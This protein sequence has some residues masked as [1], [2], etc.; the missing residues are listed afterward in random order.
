MKVYGSVDETPG[1]ESKM[2]IA[3]R[4]VIL[5]R[6]D[7]D[8]NRPEGRFG[9]V[10]M[11]YDLEE[12]NLIALKCLDDSIDGSEGELPPGWK[13]TLFEREMDLHPVLD[14][15]AIARAR[16]PV[17]T[18]YRA[19][20]PVEFLRFSFDDY[21]VSCPSTEDVLEGLFRVSTTSCLG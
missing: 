19:Y 5:R 14:H 15:P 1:L 20:L 21:L 2:V 4:Y 18:G 8:G 7:L 3:D 6:A 10:Y 11:A 17:Q 16:S 12:S 13:R 9:Q